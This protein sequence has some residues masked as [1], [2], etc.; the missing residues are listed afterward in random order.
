MKLAIIAPIDNLNLTEKGDIDMV[1]AHFVEQ[2]YKEYIS[3]Y[4]Q[5]A[6]FKILDN[7]ACEGEMQ[8]IEKVI[9]TACQ[10]NASEIVLPD[11]IFDK[12]ATLKQMYNAIQWLKDNNFIARFRVMAVPQGNTKE[13]WWQCFEEMHNNEDVNTIGISKL[14]SPHCFNKDITAARLEIT[15]QIKPKEDKQ[16]HLLGG[17]CNVLREI[18]SHPKWVR[19][20]D[21]SAPIEYGKKRIRLDEA[22][23]IEFKAELKRGVELDDHCIVNEN[24]NLIIKSREESNAS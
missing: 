23:D 5:S 20:I 8:G 11:V 6:K 10:I 15:L 24:I 4:T 14:S 19:S 7:G 18:V 21:T 9:K 2:D 22:K 17:S 12:D 13:E 1:L 3:F 16:Y